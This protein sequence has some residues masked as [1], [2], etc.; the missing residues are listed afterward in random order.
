MKAFIQALMLKYNQ[1]RVTQKAAALAFFTA[2]SLAPLL[3][4]ATSVAGFVFGEATARAE[5]V[6]QARAVIGH[7]GAEIVQLVLDNAAQPNGGVIA[8]TIG[9][10]GLLFGA[11]NIFV[12]LRQTL[13]IIWG[14]TTAPDRGMRA[15]ITTRIFALLNVIGAG[16]VLILALIFAVGLSAVQSLLPAI[17]SDNRGVAWLI[18][19]I[20]SVAIYTLLFA[21]VFKVIPRA[22]VPWK[23]VW[24]GAIATAIL[25]KVGTNLMRLYLSEG[26]MASVYGAAGSLLVVLLWLFYSAQILLVGAQIT[27]LSSR[28]R[29]VGIQPADG[30][31]PLE[32]A[33]KRTERSIEQHIEQTKS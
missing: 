14:I 24:L 1:D 27:Q 26:A 15:M 2:L 16:F 20:G 9:I 10:G 17:L 25:F 28:V 8:L 12:Q 21:F 32:Q 22:E 5:L 13:D 4:I 31:V 6:A 11:S 19:F 29:G 33:T 3:I 23:D 18:D 30:T 7:E